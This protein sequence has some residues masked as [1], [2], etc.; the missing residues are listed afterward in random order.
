MVV[1]ASHGGG[2]TP[3][4]VQKALF[5]V[6]ESK[7]AGLPTDYYEFIPHN[8]GPF[9]AAIYVDA[10]ELTLEGFL[11]QAPVSGRAWSVYHITPSGQARALQV[12]TEANAALAEYAKV[13][14]QWVKSLSFSELLRS[15]YFKYPHF[16]A[17]SVFQE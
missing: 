3:V 15:I 2:L 5:L 14:A 13:I 16:R 9:Q 4:Q 10:D 6:G 17:N 11:T 12:Q 7:L 1:A 8:Y